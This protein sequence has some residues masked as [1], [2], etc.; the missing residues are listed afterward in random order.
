MTKENCQSPH[1]SAYFA[2][3]LSFLISNILIQPK[4]KRVAD[5]SEAH[6]HTVQDS[7]EITLHFTRKIFADFFSGSEQRPTESNQRVRPRFKGPQPHL[8]AHIQSL[9]ARLSVP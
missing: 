9:A 7:S 4:R 8:I 2:V 3:P 5:P 6:L 1:D